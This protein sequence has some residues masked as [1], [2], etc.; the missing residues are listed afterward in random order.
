MGEAV[1]LAAASG[2]IDFV[3]WAGGVVMRP[4]PGQTLTLRLPGMARPGMVRLQGM[5]S[6]QGA[7]AEAELAYATALP[8]QDPETVVWQKLISG[9]PDQI[10]A[11]PAPIVQPQD[12]ILMARVAEG[13]DAAPAVVFER[14][15]A[16][17]DLTGHDSD[18]SQ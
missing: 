15:E 12:L 1:H 3:E 13:F 6:I 7:Q 18:G 8:G 4:D 5:A 10:H 14:I 17:A 9:E 16:F 2:H 11:F